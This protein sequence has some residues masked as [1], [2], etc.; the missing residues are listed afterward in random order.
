MVRLVGQNVGLIGRMNKFMKSKELEAP[1]AIHY[2]IHLQSLCNKT[3]DLNHVM[4]VVTLS[5]LFD[6]VDLIT[7]YFKIFL[8]KLKMNL[9]M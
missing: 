3:M 6:R 9:T 5:T 7:D 4:K 2:I 8:M 1:I